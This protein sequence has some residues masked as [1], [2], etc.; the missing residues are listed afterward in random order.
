MANFRCIGNVA[1]APKEVPS[2]SGKYLYVQVIEDFNNPVTGQKLG[3]D[4]WN[5]R[6]F[7]NGEDGAVY[8][9]VSSLA[10]GD[11]VRIEGR[12]HR[13]PKQDADGNAD[14]Y[15]DYVSVTTLTKMVTASMSKKAEAKVA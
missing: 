1:S 15:L 13:R 7:S 6:V 3:I 14:G 8:Q 2:P 5:C 12:V 4:V 11:R 9:L 10:K